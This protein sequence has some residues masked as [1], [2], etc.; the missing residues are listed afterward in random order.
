MIVH[1]V[2]LLGKRPSNEDN[3]IIFENIN[4]QK[5]D[6]VDINLYSIFDGHGGKGISKYLKE[7]YGNYFVKKDLLHHPSKKSEYTKYIKKVHQ[8]IQERLVKDIPSS[9][10]AGSTALSSVFFK[11]NNKI[12]YYIINTGDSRAVICNRYNIAIPLTKDHKPICYEEKKRIT[13]LGGTIKFDA[14]DWRIK[15]LS[16]SRA[17]GDMD[18]QP[19]VSHMPDIF[20]YE[21]NNDRFMIMACDGLWDVLSNQDVVDF[22]LDELDKIKKNKSTNGSGR[23]NI[24]KSLGEYAI[25]KGSQDNITII[26]IFFI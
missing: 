20:R 19:Y 21:L 10:I 22:I 17:F 26:I 1:T 15:D 13:E 23:N 24:A 14:G 7:N 6:M 8:D 18:T 4:N 9:K 11:Y 2:S 25:Q 12:Y 5:T 16:V 3:H